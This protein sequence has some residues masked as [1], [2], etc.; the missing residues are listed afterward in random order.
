MISRA[1][2]FWSV[3]AAGLLAAGCATSSHRNATMNFEN[4]KQFLSQCEYEKAAAEFRQAVAR[5]P[6]RAEVYPKLADALYELGQPDEAMAACRRG[7]ELNPE[8]WEAQ[9]VLW[10]LR[11]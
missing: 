4:G 10:E 6:G 9:R 2:K 8:L 3:A 5:E 11:L 1:L 7:L